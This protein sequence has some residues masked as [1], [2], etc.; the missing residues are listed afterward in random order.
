MRFHLEGFSSTFGGE[1]DDTM[2]NDTG[3]SLYEPH[4]AD[5]RPDLFYGVKDGNLLTPTWKR[6]ITNSLYCAIRYDKTL[7]RKDLQKTLIQ[8]TAKESGKQCFA[9]LVDWGPGNFDRVVDISQGVQSCLNI[10]DEDVVFIDYE[11]Y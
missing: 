3:L 11:F 5:Q 1:F 9:W 2:K 8:I 4:E 10:C 7:P 6:L